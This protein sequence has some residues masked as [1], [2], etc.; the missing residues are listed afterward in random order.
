MARKPQDASP[1]HATDNGTGP[2]T[3]PDQGEQTSFERFESFARKIVAVPKD[4]VRE[5]RRKRAKPAS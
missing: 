5:L 1:D 3:A 2:E 4:E